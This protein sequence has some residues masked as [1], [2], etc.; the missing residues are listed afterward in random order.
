MVIK[1]V[2]RTADGGAPTGTVCT[3]TAGG[4]A[5]GEMDGGGGIPD[6]CEVGSILGGRFGG[7]V[8]MTHGPC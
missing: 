7:L 1:F 2:G 3:S 6:A 5:I 8:P 4:L